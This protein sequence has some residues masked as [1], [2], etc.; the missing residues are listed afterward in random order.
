MHLANDRYRVGPLHVAPRLGVAT[1]ECEGRSHDLGEHRS[2]V[3]ARVLGIVDLRTEEGLRHADAAHERGRGHEDVDPEACDLGVPDRF[4]EVGTG[5]RRVKGELAADGLA[6]ARAVQ[7][8]GQRIGDGVGDRSVVLVARVEGRHV[9]RV[10]FHDRAQEAADPFGRDAPQVG[11]D[12]RAHARACARDR[13]EDR[14]ERRAL[15]G[16]TPVGARDDRDAVGGSA[17]AFDRP[18]L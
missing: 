8:P 15:P 11:V 18:V 6:H 12:D 4:G 1:R 2:E 16:P 14:P 17:H 7:R 9:V 13:L 5:E 3:G 10:T